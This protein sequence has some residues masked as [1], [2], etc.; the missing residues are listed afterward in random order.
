MKFKITA[1]ALL[2]ALAGC[3]P[4]ASAPPASSAV[5]PQTF[6]AHGVVQSVSPDLR[7]ATI[8]HDAIPGYMAA[9]TMEFSVLNT[10][11]LGGI[12]AGDEIS[13]TLAVTETNDWIENLQ[14][15]GKTNAFGVSG[16]PGW[17]VSEPELAV[18]DALPDYEFTSENGQPVR[19]SDFR[20]CAV[21]FT[22]FFTSCPLPD[23]CPRM[24]RNFQVTRK[25]LTS[26]TNT[27]ANW[28]LLSIS[29][30]PGFDTPQMLSGYAKFYRGDD[31]NRW[32]FAVASTNTL[33]G[34]APK[35]DFS[36]W[37][38]GG[39][40]SHNLRT[41]VLDPTGKIAAQFDNNDWEPEEL[42]NA[43]IAAARIK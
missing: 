37:R 15:T 24:S 13:F 4:E 41:V 23:Y 36:F 42:A 21:A 38:D 29:F 10:N 31:T 5:P 35:V 22:F 6:A 17:H 18:G 43:I 12:S 19:F 2:L 1:I 3:K 16:P 39:S 14:L 9:M 40:I 34:L 11:V 8:Q 26:A 25:I 27:T 20:G 7:R 30:D 28:Q 32:L 33:A